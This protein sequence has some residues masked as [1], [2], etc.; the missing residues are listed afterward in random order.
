MSSLAN[1][2]FISSLLHTSLYGV[3]SGCKIKSESKSQLFTK[4]WIL[5][6][7]FQKF[8]KQNFLRM[9]SLVNNFSILDFIHDSL[10]G[11]DSGA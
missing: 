1:K 6:N 3:D 9:T 2:I 7:E 5:Q 8:Q 10:C 11:L 4:S